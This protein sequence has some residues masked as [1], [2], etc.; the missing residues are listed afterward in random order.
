MQKKK[1]S[2]RKCIELDAPCEYEA[3]NDL[4][5]P[6]GYD[7]CYNGRIIELNNYNKLHHIYNI[8]YFDK[9]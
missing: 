1:K 7:Y 6:Y 5:N 9:R 8:D 3:L 4:N 2:K